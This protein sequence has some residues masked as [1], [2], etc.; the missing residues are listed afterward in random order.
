MRTIEKRGTMSS[1]GNF[2]AGE[3]GLNSSDAEAGGLEK[4]ADFRGIVALE[5]DLALADRAPATA[6]LAGFAGELLDVGGGDLGL[7][8]IDDHD[9]LAAA[10]G[11]LA[12][13]DD[14]A[15]TA[16]RRGLVLHQRLGG[17]LGQAVKL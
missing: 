15:V 5:F 17:S 2:F 7:E 8:I 6:G 14:A 4:R 13:E 3:G 12:A 16:R 10:L 1:R 9:G 11:L